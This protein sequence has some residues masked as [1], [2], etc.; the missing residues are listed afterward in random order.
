M[1]SASTLHLLSLLTRSLGNYHY[2]STNGNLG[3]RPTV[4]VVPPHLIDQWKVALHFAL[5]RN[6]F[7]IMIYGGTSYSRGN[8]LQHV[9]NQS[10]QPP[11]RRIILASSSVSLL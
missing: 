9:Y 11:H 2:T 1:T 7:D 10:N 5:R 6:T 4:I 8:V 3:D